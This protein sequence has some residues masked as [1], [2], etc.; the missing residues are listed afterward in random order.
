M[1][2]SYYMIAGADTDASTKE[3]Q[4][5]TVQKIAKNSRFGYGKLVVLPWRIQ[6]YICLDNIQAKVL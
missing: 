1:S 5:M 3:D 6:I 2:D 4:S